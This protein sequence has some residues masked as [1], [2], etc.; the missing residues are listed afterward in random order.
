[1]AEW[2]MNLKGCGHGLMKVI[3]QH[4]SGRTEEMASVLAEIRTENLSNT[5]VTYRSTC[6]VTF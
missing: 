5:S 4:L 6:S 2:L 1:M 3:S